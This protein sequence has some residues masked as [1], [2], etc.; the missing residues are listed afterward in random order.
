MLACTWPRSVTLT[1]RMKTFSCCR[2]G[3]DG[4]LA[5]AEPNTETGMTDYQLNQV[6]WPQHHP[7]AVVRLTGLPKPAYR[8]SAK[9]YGVKAP[10]IGKARPRITPRTALFSTKG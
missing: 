5:I 6:E 3:T 4:A 9:H 7:A 2:C 1:Y 8:L 10:R